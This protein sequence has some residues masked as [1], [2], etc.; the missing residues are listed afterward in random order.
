MEV[1]VELPPPGGPPDAPGAKQPFANPDQFMQPQ[2]YV[3]ASQPIVPILKHPQFCD[4]SAVTT[5]CAADAFYG[6]ASGQSEAEGE[7]AFS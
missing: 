4:A 7:V 5:E 2:P 1:H 3:P 6:R